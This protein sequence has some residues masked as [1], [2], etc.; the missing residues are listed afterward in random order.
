MM[1]YSWHWG[2]LVESPYLGWLGWG[3]LI[4]MM[5]SLVSWVIALTIG[6]GVGVLHSL[7]NR[8]IRL[9]TGTY[10]SIFRNIQ[11]LLQM[12]IWFFVVPELLPSTIGMWLKRGLPHPEVITAIVELGDRKGT[13][14][15]YSN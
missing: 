15:N 13:R 6:T 11:L 12:F 7:K 4:T 8:K 1:N 2:V 14:L 5:I 3:I 9:L 10:I